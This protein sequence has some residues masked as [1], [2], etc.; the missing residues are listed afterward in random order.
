MSELRLL[1]VTPEG[2][3]FDGPITQVT[4]PGEFGAFAVRD[5]HA[6]LMAALNAGVVHVRVQHTDEHY[7]VAGGFL[8]VRQNDV[9]ILADWAQPLPPG[10]DPEELLKEHE[11]LRAQAAR[12]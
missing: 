4:A 8:E 11:A 1:L 5:G 3:R 9:V 10:A 12:A 2:K 7:V 6:P